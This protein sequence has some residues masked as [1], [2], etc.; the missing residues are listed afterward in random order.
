METTDRRYRPEVTDVTNTL[1]DH[2]PGETLMAPCSIQK[3]KEDWQL[4]VG[5]E[6]SACCTHIEDKTGG[7]EKE[8]ER[9]WK[10]QKELED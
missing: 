4:S 6:I 1:T 3:L 2:R 8:T 9:W 7:R 5:V 10:V